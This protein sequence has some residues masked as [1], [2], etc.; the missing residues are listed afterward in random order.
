MKSSDAIIYS[1]VITVKECMA[2]FD[3]SHDFFHVERVRNLAMQ[4]AVKEGIKDL[5]LVELAALLHDVNDHKYIQKDENKEN[6]VKIKA[7]LNKYNIGSEKQDEISLIIGNM[8]FS[9]EI[10]LKNADDEEIYANYLSLVEENP[11]LG[12]VQDADR[13]DAIGA[14]G[15]ARTFCFGGSRSGRSLFNFPLN[16]DADIHQW[17]DDKKCDNTTIGHFYD[18]LLILKGMMKTET[19]KQMA[20]KKHD[21]MKQFLDQFLD[22]WQGN[23][24]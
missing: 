19:G 24:L 18:K 17:I 20:Q 4:I 22:E 9:K 21:F 7:L 3:G 15:V 14:I 8:S 5:Q 16:S 10:K 2:D 11:A 13:L 6:N 12:C 1:Y 23:I